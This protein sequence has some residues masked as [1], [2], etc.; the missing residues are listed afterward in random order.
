MQSRTKWQTVGG[1]ALSAL[2]WVCAPQ[3]LAI[4]P[5][6]PTGHKVAAIAMGVGAVLSAF[7]IHRGQ[8]ETHAA[9]AQV[10]EKF[11]Q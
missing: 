8:A 10:Q 6:T 11:G 2:A 5:D 7:G 9:I 1:A 3:N 4:L